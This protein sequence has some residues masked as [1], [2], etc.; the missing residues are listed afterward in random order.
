MSLERRTILIAVATLAIAPFSL[1][2]QAQ[3]S[4]ALAI[5]RAARYRALSQRCAKLFCQQVLGVNAKQ[6]ADTLVVANGLIQTSTDDLL[7][8]QLAGDAAAQLRTVQQDI[9][10]Y[11]GMLKETPS[12][13]RLSVV[14]LQSDKLLASADRLTSLI[15]QSAKQES[16][17]LINIA[18]RQR[19]LSQRIAKNYFLLAAGAATSQSNAQMQSDREAFGRALQTL[20]SAGVNTPTVRNELESLN[21]QWL[22]FTTAVNK[23]VDPQSLQTVATTSERILDSANNLTVAYEVA[24]RDLLGRT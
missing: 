14:N 6:A 16:A 19:M 12:R 10:A 24:L 9:T 7:R 18:G 2:A 15:E 4:T 21:A 5:N 1:R 17:G 8:A 22:F 11:S 3:I 23:G 13:E 20:S